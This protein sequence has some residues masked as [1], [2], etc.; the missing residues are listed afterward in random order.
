MVPNAGDIAKQYGVEGFPTSFVIDQK[1]MI[2]YVSL[3]VSPQNKELLAAE[4]A[5]LL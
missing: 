5:K 4:I 2:K 3:G 1:G